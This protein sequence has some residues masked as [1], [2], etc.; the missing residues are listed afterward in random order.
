MTLCSYSFKTASTSRD[1]SRDTTAA[2]RPPVAGLFLGIYFALFQSESDNYLMY[3]YCIRMFVC[4]EHLHQ[5]C[6]SSLSRVSFS[7]YYKCLGYI[8]LFARLIVI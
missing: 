2:R 8:L 3:V 7:L 6:E 4:G 5:E 1:T